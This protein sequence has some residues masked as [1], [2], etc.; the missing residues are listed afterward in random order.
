MK[1][2]VF[3]LLIPSTLQAQNIGIGTTSPDSSAKLDISGT[4]G[5]I[6]IPRMSGVQRDSIESPATGLLIFQIDGTSGFY[7]Y[8]GTAWTLLSG[9]SSS[10]SGLEEITEGA[11]TGYRIV[12]RDA[13]NYGDIGN[14]AVDLSYSDATSTTRGAS[15]SFSTAMGYYTEASAFAST[16]M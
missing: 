1:T 7:F 12:G 5:G 3:I 13:T 9:G 6:L 16:A 4:D 2:I 11:N 10:I 14:N 8:D 15:G